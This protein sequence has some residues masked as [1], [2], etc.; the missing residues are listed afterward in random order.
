[1]TENHLWHGH[2]LTHEGQHGAGAS[3]IWLHGWGHDHS[4]LMR[5]ATLLKSCG[6]HILYDLP[7]FGKTAMLSSPENTEGHST[8]D[9]AA[10]LGKQL[11]PDQKHIIIGH[12]YGARVAVQLAATHPNL[13]EAIILISGA[14]LKRKRSVLF[15]MKARGLKLLG[16]TARVIDTLFGLH[17]YNAYAKKFGSSDYKN[18]GEMRPVLVSAVNEDLSLVARNVRCPALMVY[19]SE[20][21]ETPPELGKKYETLIPVSRYEEL[22]GYGHNDIL[23]RGAYQCEALIASFLK[24]LGNG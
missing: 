23:T 8:R 17:L 7:G 1:M 12:S 21:T 16:Q 13:V 4:A 6:H 9:Y 18:A 22:N 14:G 3:L 11:P 5:M 10:A 2:S 15:K 24:D 19:G 20:D